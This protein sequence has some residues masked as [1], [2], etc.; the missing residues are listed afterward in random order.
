MV[1]GFS[2]RAN[3]KVDFQITGEFG[4]LPQPVEL[5]LFRV[6][7]ESLSN[8]RR[9]SGATK[10]QITLTRNDGS[11]RLEISDNGKGIPPQSLAKSG[12]ATQVVGVGILGMR[13]RLNQLGGRLDIDSSQ[14]GTTVKVS[15]PVAAAA[16][17]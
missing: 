16:T 10:A 2:A 17:R 6:V 15:V 9:H 14:A 11:V 8:I 4:R 7:Q 13:E 1:D 5:A 12:P 3:I